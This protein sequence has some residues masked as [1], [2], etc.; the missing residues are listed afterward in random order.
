MPNSGLSVDGVAGVVKKD[1]S[2]TRLGA[3][4]CM[5]LNEDWAEVG[6]KDSEEGCR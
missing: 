2:S 4:G 1:D 3:R 6:Q 5:T